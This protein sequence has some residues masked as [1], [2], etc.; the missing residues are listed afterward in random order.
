M[1][2][3]RTRRGVA[4]AAAAVVALLATA[5]PASAAGVPRAEILQAP[6]GEV[7]DTAATIEFAATGSVILGRFTC[8][9]DDGA[10][11]ACVSPVRYEGL[12]PGPHSFAV[13]LDGLGADT[14]PALASWTITLP[15]P[16]ATVTVTVPAPPV[17]PVPPAARRSRCAGADATA[18]TAA[19][20]R[21]ASAL[22]CLLNV[23][24]RARGLRPLRADA[25]L[26]RSADGHA[27]DMVRHRFFGHRSSDGRT[28]AMRTVRYR[29][30]ARRW[31]VAEALHWGEGLRSSPQD[32]LR[33]LLASPPHRRI[34]LAR[35]IRD[36]GV[37]SVAY[38]R[39]GSGRPAAVYVLDV[40]RRR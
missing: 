23:T 39:A 5:A 40:G 19:P 33:E 3:G 28:L 22:L 24:R 25:R 34:V 2:R 11:T 8:R 18:A 6:G 10:W 36:A 37:A 38:V 27:H 16:V 7:S 32:A 13:R 26:R 31:R 21:L 29:R 14:T 35:D 12:G 9:L 15:T 1:G 4:V 17:A 30:G 20:R